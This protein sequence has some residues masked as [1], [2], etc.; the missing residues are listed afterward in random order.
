MLSTALL[1][2]RAA[3][4]APVLKRNPVVGSAIQDSL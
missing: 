3:Q 1:Q 2:E 4:L